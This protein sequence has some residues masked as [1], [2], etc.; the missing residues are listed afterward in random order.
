MQLTE[1]GRGYMSIT[2]DP[3]LYK[4][5]ITRVDRNLQVFDYAVAMNGQVGEVKDVPF[6]AF[7]PDSENNFI[8]AEERAPKY[9]IMEDTTPRA[10]KSDY[11]IVDDTMPRKPN[12]AGYVIMDDIIP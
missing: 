5:R 11:V 2:G 7:T 4:A 8:I 12:G 3:K 1:N 10:P 9:I 6:T